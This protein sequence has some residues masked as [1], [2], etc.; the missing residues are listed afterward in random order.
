MT[1]PV[2]H[3]TF[4]PYYKWLG[5][6]PKDQPPNHYRLLSLDLYES[7]ADVISAA[8]DKQMAFIRSYSVGAS[9]LLSQKILNEIAAARVC[10]LN[11]AKK[12][13]YDRALRARAAAA[14]RPIRKPA[15][16]KPTVLILSILGA[17]PILA[18]IAIGWALSRPPEPQL[19]Q[20]ADDTHG[21][22]SAVADP[23]LANPP[24]RDSSK[25]APAKADGPARPSGTAAGGSTSGTKVDDSASGQDAEKKTPAGDDRFEHALPPTAESETP[26]NS[27]ETSKIEPVKTPQELEK[28]LIDAKT[29]DDF[30]VIADAA[31]RAAGKALDDHEQET[32]RSLLLKSLLAARKSGDSKA[33]VRATLALIKPDT[34]K[35]ILAKLEMPEEESPASPF[36]AASSAPQAAPMPPSETAGPRI[37]TPERSVRSPAG[38]RIAIVGKS[39]LGVPLGALHQGTLVT[40]Q[41]DGGTWTKPVTGEQVNPDEASQNSYRVA[42]AFKFGKS[43]HISLVT[44]GTAD[45]PFQWRAPR[46]CDSVSVWCNTSA[47]NAAL[48]GRV[49]YRVTITPPGSS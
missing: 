43:L 2:V 13:E 19:S 26:G 30:L 41:Y 24:I 46:D 22:P 15:S 48:N 7:D 27:G 36:P 20:A 18:A 37:A 3:G 5:I 49:Y 10:L 28:D 4:D 47:T 17:I 35:E 39:K 9:A 1:A 31:L 6:S 32:L 14:G 11:P 44:H 33:I 16:K 42:I 23:A 12:S 29:P 8:T 25:Q 40:L 34:V 38:R 21:K 45:R